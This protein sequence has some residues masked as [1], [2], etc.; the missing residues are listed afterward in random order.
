MQDKRLALVRKEGAPHCFQIYQW[1]QD[2]KVQ[3]LLTVC[4]EGIITRQMTG[5]VR[6]NALYA[7]IIKMIQRGIRLEN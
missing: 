6:G 4:R 1:C 2:Y 7:K 3:E 5:M